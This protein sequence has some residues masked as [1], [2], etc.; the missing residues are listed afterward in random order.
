MKFAQLAILLICAVGS[1]LLGRALGKLRGARPENV[2]WYEGDL[3]GCAMLSVA[4][5]IG[6]IFAQIFDASE[7]DKNLPW[8]LAVLMFLGGTFLSLL[9]FRYSVV[10]T[11][12]AI[13]EKHVFHSGSRR[14]EWKSVRSWRAGRRA[15]S[16]ILQLEPDGRFELAS[17]FKEGFDAL[18]DAVDMRN[19]PEAQ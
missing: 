4:L 17:T 14:V 5:G 7:F 16:I 11:A 12:D 8:T 9:V 2:I 13:L 15:G 1:W 10:V 6:F 3:L 19:I 18:L